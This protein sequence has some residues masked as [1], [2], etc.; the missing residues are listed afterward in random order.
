MADAGDAG[1]EARGVGVNLLTLLAQA[2]LPAFHVQLARR[3]GAGGYGLYTWSTAV[4]DSLSVITV[5]GMDLAVSRGVSLAR[6]K[7]DKAEAARVTG[8]ALRVVAVSGLLV[9]AAVIAAAPA[10]AAWQHKPGLVTPLRTLVAVPVAYHLASMF[11]VATQA[12]R[13]M[14]WDFWVRGLFQPISLLVLTTALLTLN[15]TVASA[16]QA[17]ALGM[18]GTAVLAAFAYNRELPLKPTLEVAARG[19]VDWKVV[20]TGLPVVITNLVW[21]LQGRLDAFLLGRWRPSEDVGAYSAAVLYVIALSQVRG[22]VY[23][24]VCATVPPALARGD[25]AGL[26]TFLQRQTRWVATMAMP[27]AVLFAGFGDGL[28]A[29]FGPAFVRAVPALAIL[30]CAHLVAALAV[31]AYTLFLS[32]RALYS[33]ASG[34][35]CLAVQAALLPVLVPRFGLTGAAAASASRLVASQVIVAITWRVVGVHGLSV[36]LGKVAV[37]AGA[38]LLVG[39]ALF[40][41][42]CPSGSRRAS[43]SASRWPR[44]CTSSC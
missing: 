27:L 21:A 12:M 32:G 6:D 23:P 7:G 10:L 15:H 38:G 11:I 40:R 42:A 25:I 37:A 26:N 13:V 1:D 9:S 24:I 19:P 34:V 22:T 31:P 17:V 2:S 3:L 28:L 4:V 44:S 20:R 35:L 43:S 14:K 16:C 41:P 29:L 8:V 39:R 18:M 5:F 30:S 33:A 36:G